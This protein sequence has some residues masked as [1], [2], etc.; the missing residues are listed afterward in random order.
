MGL[1]YD[2]SAFYYFFMTLLAI[3]MVPMGFYL[4]KRVANVVL[5]RNAVSGAKLKVRTAAE[6]KM[7]QR[8]QAKV[9]EDNKLWNKWFVANVVMCTLCAWLFVGL[10]KAVG[11]TGEVKEWSP[12]TILGITMEATDR[13]IKKAYRAMSLKYH[14]DKNP[15]DTEAA[16]TFM[17]VVKAHEALTDETAKENY[18]KYG[19]PDGPSTMEVGIGLPSF[20]LD[21]DNHNSILLVYLVGLVVLVPTLVG[22]YYRHSKKFG[23]ANV[24]VKTRA[25]WSEVTGNKPDLGV[26]GLP[27]I[28]GLAQEFVVDMPQTTQ[29][30][31]DQIRKF[32]KELTNAR[33]GQVQKNGPMAKPK[34]TVYCADRHPQDQRVF[35]FAWMM[36]TSN[37]VRAP[38][39]SEPWMRL[40]A[41]ALIHAHIHQMLLRD[42]ST[43]KSWI[44]KVRRSLALACSPSLPPSLFCAPYPNDGIGKAVLTPLSL[45]P[46]SPPFRS[47][48][49]TSSRLS[50]LLSSHRFSLSCVV[51][52]FFCAMFGLQP[53]F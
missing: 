22:L 26:K 48:S 14:P 20:L 9:R 11:E 15:G 38:Q 32:C 6:Q 46:L 12:Y 42:S 45:P 23:D 17:N 36:D 10:I 21:G 31:D 41:N 43:K 29:K 39:L 37:D 4:A 16:E 53:F 3:Y 24:Y 2:D 52:M 35:K 51:F 27:E 19:N 8:A 13:E 47:S 5:G 40:R 1:S 34:S 30:D 7:V 49:L 33:K 44:T 28:L 50:P 25:I 18:R